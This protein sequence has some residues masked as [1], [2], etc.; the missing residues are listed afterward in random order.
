MTDHKIIENK[1]RQ[2]ELE[3]A[4]AAFID[5]GGQIT[6]VGG[7][8][9]KPFPPARSDKVDPD[10]ILKRRRKSQAS[11]QRNILHPVAQES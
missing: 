6:Q 10:T 2:A 8:T 3:V 11:P 1:Q 9:L 4:K 5:S 7:F